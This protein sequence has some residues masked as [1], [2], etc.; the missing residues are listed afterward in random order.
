MDELPKENYIVTAK[1]ESIDQYGHAIIKFNSSMNTEHLNL[2]DLDSTV[3]DLYIVPYNNWHLDED[4][5][6]VYPSLNFTWIIHSFKDKYLK[7]NLTFYEPIQISPREVQDMMIFHII[8]PEFFTTGLTFKMIDENYRTLPI[9]VRKQMADS[10]FN[11][12]FKKAAETTQKSIKGGV[13]GGFLVNFI[14]AASL[15]Q[16]LGMVNSLQL[17]VHLPI[18]NVNVPACVMIVEN[19]LIPI[20]TFDFIDLNKWK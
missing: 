18:I 7:L 20:V 1:F 19:V 3:I 8:V 4:N 17:I 10:S 14:M 16:V 2:T 11:R 15:S 6:K 5:F 9:K 12:N 13:I